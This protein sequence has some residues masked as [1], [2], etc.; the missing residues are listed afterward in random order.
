MSMDGTKE[1]TYTGPNSKEEVFVLLDSAHLKVNHD[2][3]ES[4]KIGVA[5]NAK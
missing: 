5:I 2:N 3:Q 4:T 1:C